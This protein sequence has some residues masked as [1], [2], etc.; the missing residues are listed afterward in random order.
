MTRLN[1]SLLTTP[2]AFDI[3]V[4]NFFDGKMQGFLPINKNTLPHPVDIIVED[5]QLVF[6]I[7]CTG[8]PKEDIK[9][10]IEGSI[11]KVV[12]DKDSEDSKDKEYLFRS[13]SK[14][15]FN[16]GYRINSNFNLKKIEAKFDNGLLV[17]KIPRKEDKVKVELIK[18]Q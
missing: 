14:K 6:E 11:L 15:A 9:V 10:S 8:I 16:L 7:A 3:L 17:L 2:R 5:D 12:Y 4:K 1:E 18:I 13:I